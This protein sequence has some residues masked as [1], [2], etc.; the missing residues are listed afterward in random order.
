M[1]IMSSFSE[2]PVLMDDRKKAAIT[3]KLR[4]RDEERQNAILKRQ[5]EKQA[6]HADGERLD[7]FLKTFNE[8]KKYIEEF[9]NNCESQ[10]DKS[11]MVDKFEE[12][13]LTLQKLQKYVAESTLFLPSSI[14]GRAQSDVSDLQTNLQ[15][16]K[17]VIL[18]KKKFAFKNRK[19][20]S[21][22]QKPKPTSEIRS[23][24]SV[25]DVALTKCHF[26]DKK[27][28][29]L[30]KNAEEVNK[31]DVALVNLTECTVKLFGSPS[32][33]HFNELNSCKVFCGPV[34]SSIFIRNCTNCIFLLACHQL[35]I[36]QT[37]DCQFYIHVTSK[38][39][40]EA[41]KKVTFAP[42]NWEYP[43]LDSHFELSGLKRSKN[44][45]DDINDFNWLSTDVHSPNWSL[46]PE[47]DRVKKWNH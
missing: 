32:A 9:I 34:S 24:K 27:G 33:M 31:E 22:N 29:T 1:E 37:T 5:E 35:R 47:E 6:R 28:E 38:A 21:D 4:S 46:I 2:Q 11:Q 20:I 44:A 40:I 23:E 36:H 7:F 25:T 12:M 8:E 10:D 39:I 3:A 45:W 41:S 26:S 42:Y 30:V 15:K 43:G 13:S 16:K 14:L 18:P 17:E 19:K